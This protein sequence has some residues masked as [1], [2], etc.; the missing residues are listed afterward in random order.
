MGNVR[1]LDRDVTAPDTSVPATG[2]G[3]PTADDLAQ[4]ADDKAPPVEPASDLLRKVRRAARQV[5]AAQTR[6]ALTRVELTLAICDSMTVRAADAARARASAYGLYL[7][8]AERRARPRRRTKVGRVL[9]QALASLRWPGQ[10]LLIAGSGVWPSSG[11]GLASALGDLR[12]MAAYARRGPEPALQP[13]APL[14]QAW[15]LSRYPDVAAS[16]RSPLAHYLG[17][18]W[19][20]ARTPHPLF[21]P[22]FYQE[23]NAEDLAAS[24]LSALEHYV[25]VGAARG[26]DPHPLFSIAHYV[27]QSPEA[28]TGGDP[29]IHYLEHGWKQDLSPHPLFRPDWYRRRMGTAAGRMPPLVHY[30]TVGWAQGLKPHPLFD[31]LWYL[32]QYP[33][34]AEAGFEPLSHFVLAGAADRRHPSPWFDTAHYAEARGDAPTY[35]PNPLVDYLL[36][37]AWRVG[38]P[39]PGFPSPAYL[40]ARP[41]LVARGVTP[42]EHWASLDDEAGPA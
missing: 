37:G 31:P 8:L 5:D 24:G 42:L 33:D 2:E 14:A 11:R 32:A 22:L 19:R 1:P 34:V 21:A 38:E 10:A 16:G 18:G 12:R 36:G 35:D 27:S 29:L 26:R 15:Y 13:P 23:R 39:R 41:Q 40:A 20:E 4:R 9:N 17:V 6:E 7:Q 3:R 30:L 25:R 28:A